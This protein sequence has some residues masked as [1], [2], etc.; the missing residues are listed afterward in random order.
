MI[1]F[2]G[3]VIIFVFCLFLID[4]IKKGPYI[5]NTG[6]VYFINI[7]DNKFNK[8]ILDIS[9]GDSLYI[10]NLDQ[11]RHSF[12]INDPTI[13]NSDILY[14]YDD[15]R[16]I[17]NRP[18]QYTISSTLYKNVEPLIVNVAQPK[19]GVDFNNLVKDNIMK[20]LGIIRNFISN[21]VY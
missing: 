3:I 9:L 16:M 13:R 12:I 21:I 17:F 10:E 20:S 4:I 8:N 14:Q 18:G 6:M 5:Y 1:T 19:S 11:Y 15:Y 7:K 2:P